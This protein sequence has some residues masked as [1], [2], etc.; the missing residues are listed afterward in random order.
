MT[1]QS[2]PATAPLGGEP[3]GSVLAERAAGQR[4]LQAVMDT[5]PDAV[6]FLDRNWIFTFANQQ[7]LKLTR[8]DALVGEHLWTRFPHNRLEPFHTA[9]TTTMEQ[10]T[11]TE[12]EA[13]YPEPLH[14][15]YRV[16]VRAFEDGIS[17]IFDDVT[18]RRAAEERRDE[19]MQQ[20]EE[21]FEATA[22][23][24]VCIAPD[25]RCTYANAR[26][27][28]MLGDADLVGADLWTRFPGNQKEPFASNYRRA[29]GERVV[30]RFEAHY[31]DPLNIWFQVVVR[32]FQDGIVITSSDITARKLAEL[33]RDRVAGA[34]GQVLDVTSDGVIA[35]DWSWQIS[36]ANRR[37]LEM[38]APAGDV[39][40]KNL[41]EHFPDALGPDSP[42]VE[43]YSRAM[44]ER[45]ASSF[46]AFYPDPLNVW[47]KIEAQPSPDGMIV[48]FR[49]V[50]AD[51][52]A[53]D[54]LRQ[55]ARLLSTVQQAALIA[56]WELDLGSGAMRYGAGSYPVFGR[57]LEELPS[58]ESIE[59][60]IPEPELAEVR[61]LTS[62]A[63]ETASLMY[64][65]FPIRSATG[66]LVWIESRGQVIYAEDVA[67]H[68]RGI[69]IDITT[70]KRNEDQLRLS[71]TR[72]RVLTELNPQ[73]IFTANAAG[74]VTFA[75]MRLQ[76][77][78]GVSAP[79]AGELTGWGAAVHPDD[80]EAL[81][82]GWRRSI[83]TGEELSAQARVR[84]A[85]DGIYRWLEV[86]GLPLRDAGGGVQSWLCV[87]TDVHERKLAAEALAASETQFRM[88]T[89]LNP[90]FIWMGTAEGQVSYANQRFLEYIGKQHA[91]D[92]SGRWLEA[93]D[94]L[95]RGRVTD[96]WARSVATG[97]DYDI[98]ARLVRDADQASR[99]FHVRAQPRR[100]EAGTIQ[101]WLGV[102][103]DIHERR[104]FAET[105]R[106]QQMETE[107]QRAELESIYQNTPIG[108]ALFD[109]VE[110]RYLRV[111]D[112]LARA[113]GLPRE[114]ILGRSVLEIVPGVVTIGELFRQV[115]TG[116]PVR[117]QI[118]EAEMLGRPGV[119]RSWNVNY[120]PIH[121]STGAIT[122]ITSASLE[123]T[124]QRQA[125]AALMQSEKLAA[126]GR[127]ASSISHEINNPLE[128]I[129]NLLYLVAQSGELPQELKVYVHMAQSELGRVSQI[130]TQTLRFHRQSVG[131]TSV[132]A[133]GLVR[134]VLNLYQGR[135]ANS[136]I[137]V[138]AK[139]S[140]ATAM[141]CFENDIR[142]VLN[143]LIANAIDAMRTGGRMVIR[144]HDAESGGRRGV[145][146]A[147]ADTGH[148]MSRSTL[149]RL[150]EPFYTTK[151]LN[152]TG[153]GLWISSEIVKRH[154]GRLAVRSSQDAVRHGTVFALFL[155][156]QESLEREDAAQANEIYL[157]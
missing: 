10:G 57:P 44:N 139:F 55:Q 68:L 50:T 32:P 155:P 92:G 145:R 66:E 62:Q 84:R 59:Q 5:L 2:G 90:Q 96:A 17:I 154:Q 137:A 14:S 132:T 110:F 108:L 1:P 13:F 64:Q 25:W 75:N 105:L 35:F 28:E 56:T 4:A 39:L 29:M 41:W 107:R 18:A 6:L 9:Y 129:T 119:M 24:I 136:A 65:E 82:R 125:E 51:R 22:D 114:Q 115:A 43:H 21:V 147:I 34:L 78:V 54:E 121:D 103:I 81:A 83:E 86:S 99:W 67:T 117:N 33:E 128:A 80:L 113:I 89:D 111:N 135:L 8:S 74:R 79:V 124:Q 109:P 49:D 37:A 58:I 112:E 46:E 52:R 40:G 97:E 16:S 149:K 126:V 27:R 30:T 143:N 150:F 148:G 123:V 151:G 134:A 69:S 94:V 141:L 36:F 48:F 95:D 140:S 120:F 157:P 152:G 156:L 153:L 91:P 76:E 131:A 138:N 23:A 85:Q 47:L 93:F 38:L 11:P 98:E 122:G 118:V 15:W 101:S 71:E 63:V 12:F 133:E 60:W 102:A 45:I 20:L 106:E 116:K 130:A 100:S 72:Y 70:R 87:G 88:L 19:A 7:A 42:Y 53:S 3:N 77:F 146:I 127:L 61:R 142:Q 31:A 104:T 144:A 26:A 73:L